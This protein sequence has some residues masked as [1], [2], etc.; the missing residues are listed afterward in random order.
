MKLSTTNR[1]AFALSI[2]LLGMLSC[3]Q[4]AELDVRLKYLNRLNDMVLTGIENNEIVLR[5]LGSDLGGR[6]YLNI[7]EL[8]QQRVALLFPFPEAYYNAVEQMEQGNA[9]AA[10]PQIQKE[11][12]PLL[13]YFPLSAL[14]GNLMPTVLSYL[15]ALR[16]AQRWKDAVDVAIRIPLAIAPEATVTYVGDMALELHHSGEIAALDLLHAHIVQT[17]GMTDNQLALAM[18]IADQWR[19]RQEYLRAYQLYQKIQVVESSQQTLARLWVAYCSFYLGHEIVPQIF[20]DVLPEMDVT[21]YGYSLRELIKAR[22]RYREEAYDTAIR[23]AAE[24]KTYSNALDPWYPELLYMVGLLYQQRGM[25]AAANAAYREVSILFP[26][27]PW[28]TESLEALENLTS[29]LSTL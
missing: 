26:A 12:V 10:L 19:E 5:P 1:S 24:G 29:E 9:L 3:A 16:G 20:L 27:S 11:A 4:A 7:D 22:L 2:F 6:A 23:S 21:T 14:P 18:E 25:D 13:D 28:A 8:Q 15:D 17:R